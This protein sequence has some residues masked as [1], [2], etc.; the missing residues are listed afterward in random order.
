MVVAAH[1]TRTL[2]GDQVQLRQV[3]EL[4]DQAVQQAD[5]DVAATTG[6]VAPVERGQDADHG[7]HAPRQVTHGQ[8]QLGGWASPLAV[9]AHGAAQGLDDGVHRRLRRQAALLAEPAQ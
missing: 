5:V 3:A 7:P 1:R 8:T 9:H 6:S 4:G 2:A